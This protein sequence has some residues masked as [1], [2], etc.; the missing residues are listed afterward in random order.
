[1]HKGNVVQTKSQDE[2]ARAPLGL[3][4]GQVLVA[5]DENQEARWLPGERLD[6]L[7]EEQC[8]RLRDA[9]NESRLA[10]DCRTLTLTYDQ[11]DGKANQLARHLLARGCR[12]GDK[13]ALLFDEPTRS[14]V[15]M[16]AVLK[17]HAAYVPL[18]AGYPADRLSYIIADADVAMVLT[19]AHL[20]ECL[21][22]AVVPVTALD[23][24]AGLIDSL[25]S[26]RLSAVEKG[27]STEQ[28]AYIIYTSGT[29]G[30]PKGVAIEHASICNFVRV[31]A[32]TYGFLERDRVY[33]GMTIAFDFS[34][35]EIWVPWMSGATL[36]PKPSGTALL[37]AELAE[38]LVANRITAMCCV[39]TLLATIDEDI[40][41]L[42]FLLVS[43]EACPRDLIVRWH[44]PGR[45]FLNVYGPTEAT[46][47]ATYSVVDPTRPV[48]L[49][50]P[51]PSY[52][53]VILDPD[54]PMALPAGSRGE[55]GLAGIGLARGYVNRDDLTDKAF[56]AD[57][58]EIDNNPSGR[59]YRTGDLGRINEAGE[60]EYFGRIDT[61]VKIRGYRIELTEIESVLL[62]VPGVAQAVVVPY[63]PVPGMAELVAYYSLRHDTRALDKAT[64][65]DRLQQRLP[66]YM[67]PAY[68]EQ[69][70]TIPMLPSDKA[71][72]KRLPPPTSPRSGADAQEY[73]A[74][75]NETEELLASSL[76]EVLKV[77][78]VST[79]ANFFSDLGANS[80][81]LAYFCSHTRKNSALPPLA[82]RDIYQNPTVEELA[83][84]VTRTGVATVQH[85]QYPEA[86]EGTQ[87]TTRQFVTTGALQML[88]FLAYTYVTVTLM[89]IGY[90]W[91]AAAPDLLHLWLR[92]VVFGLATFAGLSIVPIA[93]K[94][95]LV[96]RWTAREIP[97]WSA[98]YVKFWFVKA[99]LL[100]NPLRMFAGT[101][102]FNVYLRLL[103][104]KIGHDVAL[105]STAVPVCTDLLTIGDGT[106]VRKD[107]LYNGYRA[108]RGVIQLGPVTLGKNVLVGEKTV[109]DIDTAMGDGSQL[110][111]SSSL[112]RGQVV[113]AHQSWHG[114]PAQRTDT[115]YRAVEPALCTLRRK[116]IYS[117]WVVFNRLFLIAPLGIF[118]VAE[119]LP[120][121]L[122]SGLLWKDTGRF[123]A[124]L[125]VVSFVAVA[126]GIIGGLLVVATLPRLLNQFLTPGKV[127]PLY[128]FHY[129]VQRTVARITNLRYFKHLAGDSSLILYYLN[130]IG[131][132]HP[133]P[134]QTG[135]NYGVEV[136]HDTPFMVTVGS[137]TMVSDGLSIITAE[138]SNTSFRLAPTRIGGNNFFGNDVTYPPAGKT[139]ENCLFGTRAMVPIDGSIR[140][141]IGLLGSPSFEIP[142]SVQR[143][144]A[145]D[146]LKSAEEMGM[147]L[148]AKNRHNGVTLAM[149]LMLQWVYAFLALWIGSIDLTYL[150]DLG[151][152]VVALGLLLIG[153]TLVTVS[154]AAERLAQ[155]GHKLIPRF[156]S[157]YEVPFWN[158]ERFWKFAAGGYLGAFNGTPFK[159]FIWRC[160]GVKVGRRL[161]DDG[162]AIPE[163]T[164]VSLGDD[165]ILN[166]GSCIQC[167]S[168]ED[169]AF[170]LDSIS[171]GSRVTIGVS[172]YVHYGVTM[173][174]DS[175]LDSDAFLMK[176]SEVPANG[177]FGGNPA[178][179]LSAYVVRKPREAVRQH[180]KHRA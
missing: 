24:E 139:G 34:V 70:E 22:D 46:V 107:C 60:I 98:G 85:V 62:Q 160:L 49:G 74:P 38:F 54:E 164:L 57:F 154:I 147:R 102:L 113:P 93:L 50:I 41:T 117:F 83:A 11:L 104:A 48:T 40:P 56:I 111:H 27:S 21:V 36:V 32:D 28:L 76:A 122:Q 145:F 169:G 63:E 79:R 150:E 88:I 13:I 171:I 140:E 2:P 66:G 125:L 99:L 15:G 118:L 52:S 141:G 159:S 128:G 59:I 153:M 109:L 132:H 16:L 17:I 55:I 78:V 131:Y 89:V 1:M 68:L 177:M 5:A 121:Y 29:T 134:V 106:V 146:D 180:G 39:P 44:R 136:K 167:H 137:G 173:H 152:P 87:A 61:Q 120:G 26:S 138:V 119:F 80:L 91:A 162:C 174:D 124:E 161:F 10:V 73:T 69:L 25:E 112:Q 115:D 166:A 101:P 178:Q 77:E 37:G 133:N 75:A 151:A 72:R 14:F 163:K 31:A 96:G 123:S 103:G 7:F 65:R 19:L 53:V 23:E 155:L 43:G 6:Q 92:S 42:R 100:S 170:K 129:A 175:V 143:D 176:G 71:D 105:F 58:L 12:S 165:T 4:R 148:P 144:A 156:C 116:I 157:I 110:G 30:R 35:E 108:H 149:F 81:L 45:R 94:W 135:S 158:H 127:Y 172:G 84:V 97:I 51:L 8:D 67:V 90:Y 47:T 179:D 20:R 95:M 3:M 86:A 114:T 142:R 168:M 126:V 18:D 33:Q 64:L 130:W 82:M 9:G